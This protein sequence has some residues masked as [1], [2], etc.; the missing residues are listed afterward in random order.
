MF[1]LLHEGERIGGSRLESG[2]PEAR[3]V[4]GVFFNMGG[5][6]ALAGWL[7][8]IGGQEDEGVVFLVMNDDFELQDGE[9]LKVPFAEGTLISVPGEDEAFIELSD[10]PEGHYSTHFAG[11]IAAM[12]TGP[13]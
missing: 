11:H 13:E 3:S 2:D 1:N 9:G 7:K 8:S 5:S 10:I 12:A 6:T 4:S